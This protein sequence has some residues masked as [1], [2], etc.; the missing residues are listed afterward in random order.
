MSLKNI[1]AIVGLCLI[2][3]GIY[4]KITA[5]Y[6]HTS[7]SE[8]PVPADKVSKLPIM[9][10]ELSSVVVIYVLGVRGGPKSLTLR[11]W[12]EG[13]YKNPGVEEINAGRVWIGS[14]WPYLVIHIKLNTESGVV[15]YG[16]AFDRH[17][18]ELILQLFQLQPDGEYY[19]ISTMQLGEQVILAQLLMGLPK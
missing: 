6:S 7:S 13:V 3:P 9:N 12:L 2:A 17:E 8:K 19:K 15:T 18:N 14:I 4:Y 16:F 5:D 11:E 1:L 10:Y